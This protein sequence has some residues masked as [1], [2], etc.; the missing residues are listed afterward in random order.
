[1]ITLNNGNNLIAKTSLATR[2]TTSRL[3]HVSLLQVFSHTHH[4]VFYIVP[5]LPIPFWGV[6]SFQV[7]EFSDTR[8][9]YTSS[10]ECILWQTRDKIKGGD[11]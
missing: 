6:F 9:R 7:R 2:C 8:N 5:V 11:P 3:R 4:P 10:E 1:M